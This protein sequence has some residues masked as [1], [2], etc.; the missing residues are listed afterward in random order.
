MS[1]E[2]PGTRWTAVGD[3]WFVDRRVD[4]IHT[5]QGPVASRRIEDALYAYGGVALCVAIGR[6]EG[7]HQVPIA[8]VQLHGAVDLDALSAAVAALPEY[9]RPRRLR[10]VEKLAMTDGFRPLKHGVDVDAPDG[11][12][13]DPHAQHYVAT[14]G[15]KLVG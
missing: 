2:R 3:Y 6:A 12:D 8:A 11:F 15:I 14:R 7:A 4:M 9:A 13:W 5:A 1:A 10:V